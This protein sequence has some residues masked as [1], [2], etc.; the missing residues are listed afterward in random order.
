MDPIQLSYSGPRHG[1]RG[2]PL[3]DRQ[4]RGPLRE[5]VSWALSMSAW[6]LAALILMTIPLGWVFYLTGPV[7]GFPGLVMS[8]ALIPLITMA[9]RSVRRRRAAAALGYL[10]Q[11]IRL[12]LPLSRFLAAAARSERGRLSHE[13]F[14]LQYFLEQGMTLSD[15][16]AVA[17]PEVSLRELGL[18]EFAERG[19]RLPETLDRLIREELGQSRQFHEK[20][21][22]AA[23]YPPVLL[24]AVGGCITFLVIF[25]FPRFVYIWRDFKLPLPAITLWVMSSWD[26]IV[27]LIP[28]IF[29][30][31]M[32]NCGA[33]LREAT[34]IPR[35]NWYL[36]TVRDRILW[37]VPLIHAMLRD[38]AM[39]DICA[40]LA[41]ASEVGYPIA[42]ALR[43]AEQL[44]MNVV[45]QRRVSRWGD[46]VMVGQLPPDAARTAR[47]PALLVGMLATA[48]QASDTAEV[49]AFVSRFYASRFDRRRELLRGAYIPVMTLV[50]GV[51]VAIIALAL[52][53]PLQQL[54]RMSTPRWGAL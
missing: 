43:R 4:S 17:V 46:G 23:W 54:I 34:R 2:N 18:I 48:R 51:I 35:P 25:V 6:S 39:A 29:A 41:D 24:L 10:H 47:M 13:L 38:R 12:N 37:R 8:V 32:I 11:A 53:L 42:T 26:Y 30:L 9:V 19:G 22:L 16:L 52:F 45:M 21:A 27:W 50:M 14:D 31:L 40:S 33:K 3:H 5:F 28:V 15:S 49:F 1:R 44:E 7:L 20:R 36:R